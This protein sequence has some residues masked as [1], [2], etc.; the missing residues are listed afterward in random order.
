MGYLT[1]AALISA[2]STRPFDQLL[3]LLELLV[4]NALEV[5]WRDEVVFNVLQSLFDIINLLAL[6]SNFPLLFNKWRFLLDK[7]FP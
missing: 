7:R 5:L 6:P 1:R 2:T 4:K 3:Q